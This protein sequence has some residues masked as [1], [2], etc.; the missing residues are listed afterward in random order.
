MEHYLP[1]A[2]IIRKQVLLD[3]GGLGQGWYRLW[4]NLQDKR[5]KGCVDALVAV[6]EMEQ[7]PDSYQGTEP[8]W[9]ATF[10]YQATPATSYLRASLPARYLPALTRNEIDCHETPDD[11]S[12][13]YHRG[14]SAVLLHPG[15]STWALMTHAMQAKGIKVF[16]EVDDNYLIDAGGLIQRNSGWKSRIGQSMHTI[17]GHRAIVAWADGVIATTDALARKYRNV[18]KT[19]HVCPNQIDPHDWADPI[20]NEDAFRIGWFASRSHAQDSRLVE[21][22]LKWASEQPGVEVYTMGLNPE[23]WDIRRQHINWVADLDLYRR[24][25]Q[26]LDVGVCPVVPTEWAMCRSD[27]K[28]LEYSMGQALPVMSD[29]APYQW[30]QGKPGILCKTARDFY[31]QIKWCVGNQDEARAMAREARD[32]VMKERTAEGNAWRYEEAFAA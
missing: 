30:W 29:V 4:C 9:K 6:P 18:G 16:V 15:D 13:P 17:Q 14:D 25:M 8:D 20:K 1:R 7:Q 26:R 21:R 19:T 23:W 27:V 12:F 10:Y 32:L 22:A 11:Y 3:A 5:V 31:H 28:A 2:A 24:E